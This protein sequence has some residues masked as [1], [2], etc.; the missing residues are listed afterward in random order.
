[1]QRYLSSINNNTTSTIK[2]YPI[3]APALAIAFQ[4]K[5]PENTQDTLNFNNDDVNKPSNDP[6]AALIAFSVVAP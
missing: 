2:Y 4:I 6:K 1:M 5:I 3:K